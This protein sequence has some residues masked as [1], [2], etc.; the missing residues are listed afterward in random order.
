MWIGISR[1]TSKKPASSSTRKKPR[2]TAS[3]P[4]RSRRPQ[5]RRRWRS[6]S[7]C[8]ISPREGRRQYSPRTAPQRQNHA[9]GAARTARALRRCQCPARTRCQRLAA[10]AAARAGEGRARHRRK[11]IYHK[12]LMP[13]TY[14]IGDVAGVV[15][16]PVYAI[17]QM[18]EALK[19][20]D[21]REFGGSGAELQDPQRLHAL[22][23]CR[24]R[25]EMGRR[26]AHHH[27]GLPRSR[28]SPSARVSS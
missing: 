20:L 22:Q 27:R 21:T 24:T 6:P 19:K 18:N 2:C 11:S 5:N 14:V 12:N 15:E 7:I 28:R 4:P 1:P 25:D 17:F 13:V 26:V 23:R 8:C 9:R 3:A 10:R 16:S